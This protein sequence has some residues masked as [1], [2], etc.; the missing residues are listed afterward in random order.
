MDA[1]DTIRAAIDKLEEL[2]IGRAPGSWQLDGPDYHYY[3]GGDG[4]FVSTPL[5]TAGPSRHAVVGAI[6]PQ[7]RTA[8]SF[9]SWAPAAGRSLELIVTLHRTI[10]AQL[11][12]LQNALIDHYGCGAPIIADTIDLARAILGEDA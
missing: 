2:R 8:Q 6:A 5:V 11:A 9:E 7:A 4:D 12:I 1:A 10:D 3:G